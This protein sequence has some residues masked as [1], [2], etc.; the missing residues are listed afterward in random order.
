MQGRQCVVAPVQDKFDMFTQGSRQ[1]Y[2]AIKVLFASTLLISALSACSPSGTANE[3]EDLPVVST[4]AV[5]E[6]SLHLWD[7][8]NGR[9][10]AVQRVSLLPRV[11]GYLEKVSFVEGALVRKGDVLFKIDERDYQAR[12]QQ[13]S[14]DLARA[15][16]KSDLATSEASRSKRLLDRQATSIEEWEQR[17]SAAAQARADVLAAEGAVTRARLDLDWTSVRAPI[18]GRAGRALFTEGNL[19]SAGDSLLT[20]LVSQDSVYVYF[21]VDESAYRK[22]LGKGAMVDGSRGIAVRVGLTGETGYPHEGSLDFSDNQ[23]SRSTGTISLRAVFDNASGLLTPGSYARVQLRSEKEESVLLVDEK[24][25]LTDQSKKY[26]YVIDSDG[27]AQRRDVLVGGLAEGK[28]IVSSGLSA[29]ESVIFEGMQRIVGPGA[30]VRTK[31]KDEQV[32]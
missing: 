30:K 16:A 21:D 7:Q 20:T 26:V 25:V 9:V 6:K 22:L 19:I 15:R 27:A 4:N 2:P 5:V 13:A 10:E 23:L 1:R 24:A 3:M 17:R 32:H 28:R 29:G 31:A 12:L 14:A 18:D 11:S 8:F